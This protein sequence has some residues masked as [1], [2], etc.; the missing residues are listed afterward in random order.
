MLYSESEG[1][2]LK[3]RLPVTLESNKYTEINIELVTL[4]RDGSPKLTAGQ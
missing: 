4:P 2:W 1:S 3:P